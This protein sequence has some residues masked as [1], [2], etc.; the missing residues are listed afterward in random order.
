MGILAASTETIAT[1]MRVTVWSGF[2]TIDSNA[3][4]QQRNWSK[5]TNKT[6]SRK[7]VRKDRK[8][9]TGPRKSETGWTVEEEPLH[10][11]CTRMLFYIIAKVRL[12]WNRSIKH[13]FTKLN[14]KPYIF[15]CS[16]IPH[17]F[18]LPRM[19]TL[20]LTRIRMTEERNGISN[21]LGIW[22]KGNDGRKERPFH[23]SVCKTF[24]ASFA[25]N[26]SILHPVAFL[27]EAVWFI[28]FLYYLSRSGLI[29]PP[30]FI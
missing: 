26:L 12:R 14:A 8:I 29:Y 18:A 1:V 23:G 11:K 17:S 24:R 4:W 27:C 21:R 25:H 16:F 13:L 19:V 9:K 15:H 22:D 6:T 3:S 10:K 20:I 28:H 30:M 2:V 5:P 7:T